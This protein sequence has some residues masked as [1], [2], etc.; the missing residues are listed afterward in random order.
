MSTKKSAVDGGKW[1][2]LSTVISTVFQFLQVTILARILDPSVFGVVSVSALLINL[3]YIFSNLGFSNSIIY[4]Q[5]NDRNVLSS[6]Y[7]TS[8]LL[9]LT[10]FCI[11]YLSA[12]LVVA[13]YKEPKLDYVIKLASIYFLIIYFGQIYLF[14]LQKEL[15]FKTIALMEIIATVAGT[16]ITIALA[17]NHYEELSLIYGQLATHVIRTLLQIILGRHLFTP[18]FY[19]NFSAIKEHLKFG[20]YNV[21]DGLLGFIQGNSDNIIVG[22]LLGVKALG[23]YTIASQ[24]AIFPI[25]K[26]SPIILQVAYPILAKMKESD[27][28]LKKAYLSILDLVSY[29]NIPLLAGL[30]I[31]ADSVVPLMYGPG[32]EE[33]IPLIKIFVFVSIFYCLSNPL[34]TLA[35]TKGKP[36]LL[37]YL[38]LVTLLVKVPLLYLLG[39]RWQVYGIATAFLL[40][41][42][43]NLILNFFIVQYL[44]GDFIR[45]FFANFIKPVLF[46]ALMILFI[47]AYKHYVGSDGLVH[48]LA[49]ILIGGSIYLL[50][51]FKYKITLK[52]I[53]AFR[54]SVS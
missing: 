16:A 25:T 39:T 34:F 21:G 41:T 37:F 3:F 8:L 48:T 44:V 9:G 14:L 28:E 11:A 49:Q 43:I 35:F 10:I 32:W 1:I 18:R 27:S 36:N 13:Y 4:K 54:R 31:T 51:T 15:K 2:T 12:P 52:E 30:Y 7:F 6:I 26:L 46:C 38:N 24:L 17:Y 45:D 5:E 22:G 29:L 42:F 33:T 20:V 23:Y 53:V 47:L 19:L 40:S 50:L